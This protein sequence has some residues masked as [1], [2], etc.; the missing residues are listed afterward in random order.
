MAIDGASPRHG[1]ARSGYPRSADRTR[2]PGPPS[3]CGPTDNDPSEYLEEGDVLAEQDDWE[4][5]QEV[6]WN[7]PGAAWLGVGHSRA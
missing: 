6:T 5:G 1:T 3:E 4:D 2:R 7:P